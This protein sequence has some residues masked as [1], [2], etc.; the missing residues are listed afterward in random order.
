MCRC[1]ANYG[2]AFR[3]LFSL[4]NPHAR[5]DLVFPIFRGGM[6]LREVRC[7]ARGPTE[8]QEAEPGAA[9]SQPE[10]SMCGRYILFLQWR[11]TWGAAGAQSRAGTQTAEV[12]AGSQS[13]SHTTVPELEHKLG[14]SQVNG[15]RKWEH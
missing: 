9:P 6:R 13:S 15:G 1:D 14:A 11:T 3:N 12:R 7:P 8:E 4:P 5:V 10:V 2:R